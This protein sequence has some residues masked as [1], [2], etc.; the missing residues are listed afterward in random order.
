MLMRMLEAGGVPPLTDGL[1]AADEDNPRGYWELEAVKRLPDD[2]AWL[3]HAPGR[4]LKAVSAILD[5]LPPRLRYRVLFVERDIAEVLASQRRMLERR[6]EPTDRVPDHE[7]AALFAR[8]VAGVLAR[9]AARPEMTVKTL[10]HADVLRDPRA[11]AQAIDEFLGGGLDVDAMAAA[12][13][14]SLWRQRRGA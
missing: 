9:A 3:D 14:P 13:D 2:S 7:M 1:R 4:A 11:A 12:V 5:K 10:R 6:G 8:H